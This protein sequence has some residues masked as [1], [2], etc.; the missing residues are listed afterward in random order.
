VILSK[1]FYLGETEVTQAQYSELMKKNPSHY[2]TA[3]AFKD[4]AGIDTS[5]FPVE[6]V[7]W[8]D[9]VEF[10]VRLSLHEGLKPHYRVEGEDVTVLD[11][12]G[13]RLPTEA[14]W[15]FAC[16]A[17][18]ETLYCSG[19]TKDDLL[20]VGWYVNTSGQQPKPV[21]QLS[22]NWFGLYDIHGNVWEWCEDPWDPKK[23]TKFVDKSAADPRV[24]LI[25]G[26]NKRAARGGSWGDEAPLLRSA[27][28]GKQTYNETNTRIGFRVAVSLE[29]VELKTHPAHKGAER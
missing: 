1:P 14:E 22:P 6:Q 5:S 16:R 12:N 21:R 18:T 4:F 20:T 29:A 9:A 25:L 19:D 24:R 7:R 2:S 11:G 8:L 3:G 23:Y 13:Y 26:R 15:E 10:C 28:R 27:N 17:G